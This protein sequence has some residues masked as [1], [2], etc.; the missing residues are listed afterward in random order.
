MNDSDVR[1]LGWVTA[2]LVLMC[3]ILTFSAEKIRDR[4]DALE[5]AVG[6]E[7]VEDTP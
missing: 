3:V 4:L 5:Q 6:I 2:W 7:Q 1:L